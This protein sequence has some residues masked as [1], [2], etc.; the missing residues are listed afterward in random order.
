MMFRLVAKARRMGRAGHVAWMGE[1]RNAYMLLVG[2]AEGKRPL[3][4]SRRR[5][6]DNIRWILWR[7]YGVIWTGLVWLRIGTGG[8]LLWFGIEPGKLS[9]APTTGDHTEDQIFLSGNELSEVGPEILLSL[10]FCPPEELLA[11]PLGAATSLVPLLAYQMARG[12]CYVNAVCRA[13]VRLSLYNINESWLFWT[14]K[15][16]ECVYCSI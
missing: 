1:K 3:G 10:V 11:V 8:E 9:S 6:V 5:W 4:R 16:R 13:T 12:C 2:K 14:A 7:W 15:G